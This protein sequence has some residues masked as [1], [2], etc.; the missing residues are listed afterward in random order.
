[1]E[2]KI[3]ITGGAGLVGQNLVA[4]LKRHAF[5]KIVCIDKSPVNSAIL[6]QQHPDIEVIVADLAKDDG[7]QCTLADCDA[8]R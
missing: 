3:I 1:M 6:R 4:K 7:W 8:R 2:T 5:N